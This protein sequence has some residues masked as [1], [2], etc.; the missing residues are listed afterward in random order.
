MFGI[1]VISEDSGSAFGRKFD[2]AGD[3]NDGLGESVDDHEDR[4][5]SMRVGKSGDHVNRKCASMVPSGTAFG[6][7]GAALACI[8][9][10][11]RWHV[12]QPLT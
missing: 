6:W 9:D 7:S 3:W 10:F 8:L 2:I 5:V 11:V 1:Y 4:V 12:S